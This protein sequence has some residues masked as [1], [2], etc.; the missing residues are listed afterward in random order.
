MN[1]YNGTSITSGSGFVYTGGQVGIGTA[2]PTAALTVNGTSAF[3]FGTDF[4]TTGTQSDVNLGSA[5]SVR[6]TGAGTATFNGISGGVNGRVLHLHNGSTSV[7]TLADKASA[8]TTYANQIVTGTGSNLSVASNSAVILQY[9]ASATNSN[10]ASGAWRVIGGSVSGGVSGGTANYVPLWTSATTLGTSALYQSG[11]YVGIGTTLPG[12]STSAGRAYLTLS[13]S[14]AN[15]ALEFITQQADADT[16][17]VGTIQFT[18]KNSAAA[19]T[20]I[21]YIGGSLSGSVA[22]NRGGYLRF[23]TKADGVSGLNEGMRITNSGYVGIGT[24]SPGGK[25]EVDNTTTN[26]WSLLTQTTGGGANASGF[27]NQSDDSVQM[28][29]R[30]G[31][32]TLSVITS[33]GSS[34]L[35]GGNVGIGTTGPGSLLHLAQTAA[36][37]TGPILYIQNTAGVQSG[38]TGN[39]SRIT[40][41]GY[42]VPLQRLA[43][44]TFKLRKM[45]AAATGRAYNLARCRA[46]DQ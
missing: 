34:Y 6:Y 11:S 14:T 44:L 7:L 2:N 9:D 43:M 24:T 27:W 16:N 20:R 33:N 25:L 8:D 18:D 41:G 4:S 3:Q 5:S 39:I 46:A 26:S 37:S 30:S 1:Y 21:A 42:L 38:A 13:G 31:A 36:A 28:A 32:G 45:A 23:L 35:M 12:V 29:L 10:G 17:S 40:F 22:N 15:G 19:D